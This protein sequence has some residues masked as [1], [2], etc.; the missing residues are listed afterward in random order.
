M[1]HCSSSYFLY[2]LITNP[3]TDGGRISLTMF[4]RRGSFV[5][6][7]FTTPLLF[8]AGILGWD[9]ADILLTYALFTVIWQ[10]QLETPVRNEVD[11]LDFSRGLLAI[12]SAVL[13]G[14]ILLPML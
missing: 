8:L 10:R 7:L 13:V 12:G 6:Q 1:F 2:V 9:N 14:L 3:E 5:V 11:E 4:G